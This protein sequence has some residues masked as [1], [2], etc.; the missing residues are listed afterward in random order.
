MADKKDKKDKEVEEVVEEALADTKQEA[1]AAQT[2]SE[3]K[4]S[5]QKIYIK[6]LS[7]EAPNSPDSFRQQY[8]PQVNFNINTRYEKL[9]EDGLFDVV[10]RL[11]VDVKQDEKTFFVVEI[12]Q[13]GIFEIV[14]I[15]GERLEQVITITCPTMLFPY[16]REAIDNVVVKGGFPP[17]QLAPINFDAVYVQAKQQQQEQIAKAEAD[18]KAA[19]EG[20]H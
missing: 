12:Q 11:T 4:F 20:A 13:A 19:E 9:E 17:L 18:K 15:E 1:P 6:D 7:F 5:V 14:K 10:L 2:A 3:S 8:K 16:A